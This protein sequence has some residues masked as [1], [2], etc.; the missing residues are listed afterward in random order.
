MSPSVTPLYLCG[1]EQRGDDADADGGGHQQGIVHPHRVREETE[2]RA[3]DEEGV[4][5]RAEAE[6]PLGANARHNLCVCVS[7]WMS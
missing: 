3:E 2:T 7:G 6:R 4:D 1:P 5:L